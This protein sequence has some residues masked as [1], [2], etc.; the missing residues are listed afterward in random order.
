MSPKLL[1]ILIPLVISCQAAP[2]EEVK[3]DKK[4]AGL[5]TYDQRQT[6]KYNLHVN[7]KDVQF[8][9]LSDSIAGI[10]GDYGDYEDY[11]IL[12]GKLENLRVL[13]IGDSSNK[14]NSI[15]F[16][17]IF[18]KGGYGEDDYDVSHLTVN[19]ILALLGSSQKPTT[20]KPTDAQLFTES[21]LSTFQVQ[22]ST[23]KKLLTSTNAPKQESQE[24]E[25]MSS[26][27]ASSEK[28]PQQVNE[29]IDYEE[30]PV[31]VQYYRAN[32]HKL[33]LNRQHAGQNRFRKRPSVVVIDGHGRTNNV[34][35]LEG[36]GNQTVKICNRGEFR[37]NL[38]RCRVVR[39]RR[40][41]AAAPANL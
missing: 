21:T 16:F 38:G 35:I 12:E 27:P 3:D 34:K 29:A 24:G 25:L 32:N 41:A 28:T 13:N 15:I 17:V 20:S 39:A 30:I 8:F 31:E 19:P 7:I 22:D 33:P 11:D 6:G 36:E 18:S 5:T 26:E 9:S 23:T 1:V 40:G 10:G 14:L 2:F 4:P 37:D